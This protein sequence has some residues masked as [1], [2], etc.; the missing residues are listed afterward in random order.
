MTILLTY[1][2][3]DFKLSNFVALFLNILISTSISKSPNRNL[4]P[5]SKQGKI[6]QHSRHSNS[7]INTII[8]KFEKSAF[9]PIQRFNFL[10]KK[11]DEGEISK[12]KMD[13]WFD[14]S[15]Q[16]RKYCISP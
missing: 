7:T 10:G 9:S 6:S 1:Q 14:L 16:R 3:A 11:L 13:E 2:L 15:P 5:I 8:E 12:A 4:I